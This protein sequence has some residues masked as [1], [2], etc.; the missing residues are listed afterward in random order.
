MAGKAIPRSKN[1]TS[2]SKSVQHNSDDILETLTN[3]IKQDRKYQE[4]LI[5]F[6]ENTIQNVMRNRRDYFLY[7]VS[8]QIKTLNLEVGLQGAV[9]SSTGEWLPIESLSKLRA[10]VGGRFQNIKN[11]WVEAGFPLREHRGDRQEEFE[12]NKD[13]WISL[14]NWIISQGYE[15]RLAAENPKCLFEIRA[16]NK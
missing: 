7:I 10:I 16:A 5:K 3:E 11:K 14:S 9:Q 6:I 12:V 8:E 2:K 4:H 13:G 15:A 1:E